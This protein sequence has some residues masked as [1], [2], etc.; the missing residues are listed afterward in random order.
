[1]ILYLEK[2][3]NT[4]FQNHMWQTLKGK[5]DRIVKAVWGQELPLFFSFFFF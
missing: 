5:L 3:S 1:M 2:K 4:G